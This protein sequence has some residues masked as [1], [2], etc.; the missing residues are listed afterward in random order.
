M[1]KIDESNNEKIAALYSAHNTY[2]VMAD[3]SR[4]EG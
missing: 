3:P 2:F 4:A 1:L